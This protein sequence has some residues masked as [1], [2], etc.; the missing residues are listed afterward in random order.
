[1]GNTKISI[2]YNGTT[3]VF[4][5]S[6]ESFSVPLSYNHEKVNINGLGEILLKGE[7]ELRSVGWNSFFPDQ[8]YDFCQ[9]TEG[10]LREPNY[11]ILVLMLLASNKQT[12]T[13]NISGFLSMPVVITNFSPGMEER[14]KDVSYSITFTQD[15]SVDTPSVKKQT[16]KRPTKEVI[17]H[18]YKWKKGDTWKKVAKKETGKASNWK[19]LIKINKKKIDKAAADYHKKHPKASKIPNSA[20]IGVKFLIK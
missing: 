8:Y 17:A 5:I 2:T 20:F 6:P 10:E 11:Y 7:Q 18:L 3:L 16:A 15:K 1:M 14:G 4:P 9:V 19:R 12:V 13:L